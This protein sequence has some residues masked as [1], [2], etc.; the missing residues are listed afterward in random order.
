[1]NVKPRTYIYP[2]VNKW[3]YYQKKKKKN[4]KCLG[5]MLKRS[6][7]HLLFLH[8]SHLHFNV[9]LFYYLFSN[10]RS[11]FYYQ[12]RVRNTAVNKLQDG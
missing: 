11:L 3:V 8:F 7:K 6:V 2:I 4:I 10:R 12:V 9:S 5:A 1:M